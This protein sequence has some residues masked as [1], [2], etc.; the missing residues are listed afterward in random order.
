MNMFFGKI[1]IF[2]KVKFFEFIKEQNKQTV[3]IKEF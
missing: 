1:K 2:Q 3:T